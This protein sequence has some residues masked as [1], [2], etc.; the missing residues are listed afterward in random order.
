LAL[1]L[2][3]SQF[4]PRESPLLRHPLLQPI[5][6]CGQQSLQVF[7][8]GILLSV[9]GHFAMTEW[10]DGLPAQIAVNCAG[11]AAMI[12]TAALLGWYRSMDRVNPGA[13]RAAQAP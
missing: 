1:A 3:V 4:L 13:A 10:S 6:R 12:A 8:L 11:F 7:C 2:V 9:L 5:I